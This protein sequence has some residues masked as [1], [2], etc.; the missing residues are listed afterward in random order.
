MHSNAKC[1]E[2][3]TTG[4]FI[5]TRPQTGNIILSAGEIK[6]TK[7][8]VDFHLGKL[9]ICLENGTYIVENVFNAGNT[10]FCVDFNDGRNLAM[11]GDEEVKFADEVGGNLRITMMIMLEEG[12]NAC[13]EV[14]SMIIK[15]DRGSCTVQGIPETVPGVCFRNGLRRCMDSQVFKQWLGEISVIRRLE[16]ARNAVVHWQLLWLEGYL[17]GSVCAEF[18][19]TSSGVLAKTM[20]RIYA[21]QQTCL[22]WERP[23]SFGGG[24][25]TKNGSMWSLG[26]G[27]LNE[28]M[29][30]G[31]CRIGKVLLS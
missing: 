10:H 24:Y 1:V 22:L 29:D 27:R 20:Q 5:V 11:K 21:S 30:R 19:D 18:V 13:T 23:E 15:N 26:M 12:A 6:L 3:F 4:K 7:R 17:C 14:P 25:K 31:S 9:K 2:R 16:T 28:N 8:E